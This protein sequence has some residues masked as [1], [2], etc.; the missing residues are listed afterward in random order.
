VVGHIMRAHGIRGE[1][2]VR[3]RTDVPERRFAVGNVLYCD[4]PEV[5]EL[6]IA[7]ARPHSDRM[8]VTFEGVSDRAVAEALQGS[9]LSIDADQ[10]GSAS[11]GTDD[12]DEETWWDHEL[13]GLAARTV[14]GEELGTVTA[15][16][17]N[18][19]GELLAIARV[20]GRELLV[21][22]VRAIVPTVDPA[23]G[24]VIVDPP[25]GLLEL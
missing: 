9:V 22:F 12:G 24:F 14:D 10:I 7:A 11:G 25:P 19:G 23:G 15:V 1:V 17:H 2:A 6:V 21:P 5:P 20:G 8:L 16:L 13:V 4:H 3:A 18:P